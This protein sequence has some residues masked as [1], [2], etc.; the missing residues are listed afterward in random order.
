MRNQICLIVAICLGSAGLIRAQEDGQFTVLYTNTSSGVH[1]EA[2]AMDRSRVFAGIRLPAKGQLKLEAGARV[3]LLFNNRKKRLEGPRDYALAELANAMQGEKKSTFLSRFWDFLTNAVR[4]AEDT[5][6][7][8]RYHKRYLTNARAGI[9]GFG[10][11]AF[12]IQSLRYFSGVLGEEVIVFQWDSIPTLRGYT[13]RIRDRITDQVVFQALSRSNRL[14]VNLHEL[15]LEEEAI[16]RWQVTGVAA[17]ST[18]AVSPPSLFSY[19]PGEMVAFLRNLEADDDFLALEPAE[20]ALFRLHVLEEEGFYLKAYQ[21]YEQLIEA[22][23]DNRLYRKVFAAF[24]VRMND[25]AAAQT[26]I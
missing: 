11:R 18:L 22:Q 7:L 8:E 2:P 3:D 4:E 24:L 10:D 20:Q 13:F 9:R 12:A 16:Y 25:L 6:Q 19:Q 21:E 1:Y 14:T 26:L 15:Y 17:D 23:P 5:H